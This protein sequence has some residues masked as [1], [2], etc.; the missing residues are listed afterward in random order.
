MHR[1]TLAAALS[2]VT[3]PLLCRAGQASSL[4]AQNAAPPPAC[5]APQFRQ[6]D[7]WIGEWDVTDSTGTK[8]AESSIT[9]VSAGCAIAE[10]WKPLKGPDGHSLSWYEPRDSSWH[11]QWI[12]GDGFVARF[13]GNLEDGEMVLTEPVVPVSFVRMRYVKKPNG[14]VQQLL[15]S[16]T[17]RGA[18]WTLAF[19]GN[20]TRKP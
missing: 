6:F 17:D 18:T 8:I 5:T 13:D 7:Y 1:V 2:L 20:Y 15:W 10:H 16:S 12:G 11:Q 4:A 3:P 19:V 9:R 14:V